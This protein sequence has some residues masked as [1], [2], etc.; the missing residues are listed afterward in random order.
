MGEIFFD[1][2]THKSC[3]ICNGKNLR[4]LKNYKKHNLVKCDHCSFIFAS[5]IPTEETLANYY[6]KYSYESAQFLSPSTIQSY[7]ELLDEFEKYRKTNRIL[8]VGCGAGFFLEQS[9]KRGWEVHGTEY[10]DSAIQ[11]C[12]RN[13]IDVKEGQLNPENYDRIEFDV[14]TSFE[15]IEHI[16]NPI[17]ETGNIFGILRKGG[18]FYCTTPN[19]NSIERQCLKDKYNIISY[20]EHLSYYTPKSLGFLLTQQGFEKEKI[21][22]TGISITRIRTS[23]GTS[24]QPMISTDSDDE[25]IRRAIASY[26]P[27]KLMK[28]LVNKVL[29][30][31]GVGMS[32]KVF[33]EK[34]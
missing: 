28:L 25:K 33:F 6:S 30:V 34:K 4:E 21:L 32:L 20:P 29:T 17:E 10:S 18:L 14:V 13:K 16:N 1:T 7:N 27:M 8:D 3:L 2:D 11:L 24:N 22:T 31:F 19:F 9:K 15:V 26:P 5:D 23:L 12:K